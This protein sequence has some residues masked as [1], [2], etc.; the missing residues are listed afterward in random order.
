VLLFARPLAA[1]DKVDVI[2]LKNGDRITCEI[3]GLDRSV[4]SI[5]T[6][7]LG[8]ASVHWGEVADLA[9]P[10]EFDVQ[11]RSGQHY[12]GS[13]LAS[14]PGRMVLGIAG[15]ATTNVA[16]EDVI[17]LAAIGSSIWNRVDGSVDAGFSFAQANLETHWALNGTAT[18]R[19]PQYQLT[20]TVASQLTR[21]E[22]D[23][24][25]TRHDVGVSGNRSL[26]NRWY[27]IAW[28]QFQQNQELSLDLRAVGGAGFGRDL[29]HTSHRLW[30]TYAGAAY[31]HE[32]FSGEPGSQSAEAAVGGQL[33][34]FTPGKEDFRITNSVVSYFNLGGR[35]RVRVEWQSAWRH[36]FLKDFY[37]S[38]N[39]FESFDGHPPADQKTNDFGVSVTLGWKF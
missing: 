16:L 24:P 28:G 19:S 14:P 39:G 22:G 4:L 30:S 26:A 29:V 31:T 6:D 25:L 13:L 5:S 33:D 23:D 3:K 21:R 17:R 10:R 1:A 18:Y 36:E 11:L 7:P 35:K 27:T 20:A 37:W 2:H 9:S 34:F 38:L 12:L 32:Q 15:G 8:K